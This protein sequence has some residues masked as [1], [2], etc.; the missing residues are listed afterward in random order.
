MVRTS[1]FGG[2]IPSDLP[3]WLRGGA[4]NLTAQGDMRP[5]MEQSPSPA[6]GGGFRVQAQSFDLGGSGNSQFVPL[7]YMD[8]LFDPILIVF[9][10]DNIRET[11]RRLRHYF[12]F[13]P[14]IR[15]IIDFHTETPISDFELRCS[16]DPGIQ[17]DYNDF[18]RRS[19][20]LDSVINL[21][22]DYWLLGEGY[23]YGNWD[24]AA[25]EF[26]S[27]VQLPPEEVEVHSAY[28][29][30]ERLYVLRPNKDLGKLSDSRNPADKRLYEV[31]ENTSPQ[32]A[33]ALRE[34]K[35]FIL[36]SNRLIVLQRSMAG[37]S[38]R[39]VSPVMSVLKDLMFEDYLNLFRMVMIQRHAYPL[40]IFKLGSAERGYVP[41]QRWYKDFQKLLIQAKNDP[42]FNIITHPLVNVE[43]VTGHDKILPI[44]PYYDMV[45]S[46]IMT[47]LFVSDAV[48]SGEKTP[49]AA[50]V[51]FMRGLMHRYL[52]FRQN[53]EQQMTR[54]IFTN[55]A[56][57][58]GY[59]KRS[60]AELDHRVRVHHPDDDLIIP[61]IFWDKANLLSN[62]AIMQMVLTLRE[63]KEI[64][65]KYV[66]E[67][68][69]WDF[70]DMLEQLKAEESTRADPVFQELRKKVI[71]DKKA[72]LT[73][74]GKKVLLGERIEEALK[75]QIADKIEDPDEPETPSE[76][77]GG[78]E[79][80]GGSEF[81]LPVVTGPKTTLESPNAPRP[82][83]IGP[84]RPPL[85][86]EGPGEGKP[87][88]SGEGGPP[89]AA[90][91]V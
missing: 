75:A 53:L 54:V 49:Y 9:P 27:F 21:C 33:K 50:G 57:Q 64:P 5:A 77:G 73:S 45:K 34:N 7:L 4:L 36:D 39:G 87:K 89:P 24:D 41:P 32:Y 20:L 3:P 22:R 61:R 48:I 90:E 16:E 65:M 18:K 70:D 26:S 14:H 84:G 83:E 46:R 71:T 56:R 85:P 19:N 66:S 51:T 58:R 60:K 28:I 91:G 76:K 25:M 35:P 38:N 80:G 81:E 31:M 11:N 43:I 37:Y 47:G 68:F 69:G 44:I 72:G 74:L 30:P 55:M 52:T 42:D 13:Q 1:S 86:A 6:G 2:N 67:M 8:P 59:V 82:P 63:K 15:S 12:K 23:L 62:Q 17:R 10:Q 40:K 78:E 29:M 88:P 79:G